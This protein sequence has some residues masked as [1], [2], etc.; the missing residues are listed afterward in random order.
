MPDWSY[1]PLFRPALFRLPPERARDLTLGAIGWLAS[2]SIG[3][4]IIELAGHMRS[5]DALKRRAWCLTFASPVGIGAGLDPQAMASHALARFG[6]GF[7][8]VG[9]VTLAPVAATAPIVR[10]V[11]HQALRYPDLPVNDGV[12]A[13]TAQLARITPLPVPLGVRLAHRPAADPESAAR[14]QS[15]MM[16]DLAPYT[17]FFTLD[18]AGGCDAGWTAGEWALYLRLIAQAARTIAPAQAVLLCLRPDVH[19]ARVDHLLDTAIPL[20]ISGLV[21]GGGVRDSRHTRL[22][23]RPA[24][25]ASLELVRQIHARWG[26]RIT[27]IG[28]GGVHEPG[29]AL[30]LLAAGASLVQLCSGLIYAGPGLP[31]RINEALLA[32]EKANQPERQPVR[33]WGWRPWLAILLLGYGM[34]FGGGLAWLIAATRVVLP[35][36]EAFVQL[37]RRELA[38]LNP[39][40]LPFMAHDRI[41]LAGTMISIGV[42]YAQLALHALRYG[43]HWAQR[44]VRASA[45]VGFASFFLFLGFGY[46]DP[47]HA[48]V[49]LLL[50]PLFLLGMRQPASATP[51]IPQPDLANDVTWRSAL[52]GQLLFVGLGIG[53]VLAGSA[54]AVIGVT[55]VFVPEDLAFL[56]TTR[57][58]LHAIN[59]RLVALV[60]H[61]RAGFG[62]AL[63]SNGL[64]VLLTALWGIRRGAC[65]VWWTLCLAGLPGFIGA[66][67]VHLTVGYTDLWHVSPALAALG[68]YLLGLALLYPYLA[69]NRAARSCDH[70][71]DGVCPVPDHR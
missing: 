65:W 6:V 32:R 57:A 44:A 26:E 31:K 40:L 21:I 2:R 19:V 53:L 5:A 60:A 13:L 12:R 34:I 55:S 41:T 46:F 17:S 48:F 58:E 62:G 61:D 30:A 20:G 71:R 28:S 49:S 7:V 69:G 68:V 70:L 29:D 16:R 42:L 47:L 4:W 9:P 11:A 43:V 63:V 59:P 67:G 27:I 33:R 50:L 25:R 38:A 39:R 36:D 23:G 24:A 22:I 56:Q 15:A 3:P 64:A 10:D 45:S 1:L 18:C 54:I 14:E 51:I 8:E 37:S 35:Y 52:W 66:L